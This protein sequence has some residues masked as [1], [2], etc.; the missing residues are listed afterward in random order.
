M[1]KWL[2]IFATLKN[3]DVCRIARHMSFGWEIPA[4][5]FKK[6]EKNTDQIQ[7]TNNVFFI[8]AV[9]AAC[10][11]E[12]SEIWHPKVFIYSFSLTL[13]CF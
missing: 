12:D 8:I 3:S 11:L 10:T 9:G 1:E 4:K 5:V 7:K 13:V 6:E 2:T